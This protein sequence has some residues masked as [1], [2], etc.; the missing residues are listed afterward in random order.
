MARPGTLLLAHVPKTGGKSLSAALAEAYPPH[1]RFQFLFDGDF[2]ARR[3]ADHAQGLWAQRR[4]FAGHVS[5]PYLAL[6]PACNFV[7]V[8]RDPVDRVLSNYFYWRQEHPN[9]TIEGPTGHETLIDPAL[10]WEDDLARLLSG[11]RRSFKLF[12]LENLTCFQFSFG[13]YSP[14]FGAVAEAT[15]VAMHSLAQC[16]YVG[17]FERLAQDFENLTRVLDL[18]RLSLP[19]MNATKT[20]VRPDEI[21]ANLRDLI[22]ARNQA[23]IV[24]YDKYCATRPSFGTFGD[25]GARLRRMAG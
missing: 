21:S 18:P 16:A 1:E 19:Q 5:A 11:K 10:D 13:I 22:E 14:R 3:D 24:L 23:D 20:R 7:T 9:F 8:L 2:L 15:K 6:I 17:C 25:L 12:E 4:F